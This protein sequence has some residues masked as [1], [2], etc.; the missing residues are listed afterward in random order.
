MI[1][2]K[3]YDHQFCIKYSDYCKC[4]KCEHLKTLNQAIGPVN[5]NINNRF[6]KVQKNQTYNFNKK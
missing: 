3:K 1:G 2:E 5:Q 4:I 6:L